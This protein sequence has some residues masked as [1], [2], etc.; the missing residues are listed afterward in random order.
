MLHPRQSQRGRRGRVNGTHCHVSIG[1]MRHVGRMIEYGN[2]GYVEEEEDSGD[3]SGLGGWCERLS[4]SWAIRSELFA[5]FSADGELFSAVS[6][7]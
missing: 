5:T 1:E 3:V 4:V 7:E 6:S 2:V